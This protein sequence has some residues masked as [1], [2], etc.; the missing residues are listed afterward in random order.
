IKSKFYYNANLILATKAPYEID[1]LYIN[2]EGRYR[3]IKQVINNYIG[4][5]NDSD[6]I[7]LLNL[8]NKK[9]QILKFCSIFYFS[10]ILKNFKFLHK[11]KNDFINSFFKIYNY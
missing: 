1:S 6:I 5:Y 9:K 8:F 10:N 7:L 11:N 4:I 2:L 3:F